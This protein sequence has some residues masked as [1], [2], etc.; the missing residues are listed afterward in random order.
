MREDSG[1]PMRLASLNLLTLL[2]L[3]ARDRDLL[4]RWRVAEDDP[5]AVRIVRVGRLQRW[6]NAQAL[7]TSQALI[8]DGVLGGRTLAW[9]RVWPWSEA[10]RDLLTMV[11]DLGEGLKSGTA[12]ATRRLA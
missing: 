5:R 6:I 12:E 1:H 2:P 11:L 3:D 9:I 8:V 10:D 7:L 4:V